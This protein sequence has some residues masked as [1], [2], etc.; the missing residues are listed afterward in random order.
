M[1][2]QITASAFWTLFHTQKNSYS[3]EHTPVPFVEHQ[4]HSCILGITALDAAVAT[5]WQEVILNEWPEIVSWVNTV[6]D[7]N[8]ELQALTESAQG[9]L[10]KSQLVAT[11]RFLVNTGVPE[12]FSPNLVDLAVLI[13]MRKKT[14]FFPTLAKDLVELN[15]FRNHALHTGRKWSEPMA[16]ACIK[17]IMECSR[18]LEKLHP[19]FVEAFETEKT[20]PS[21]GAQPS[22]LSKKIAA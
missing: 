17:Q 15:G 1:K 5:Y 9:I 21:E 12:K 4:R 20:R 6:L 11:L 8:E 19:C 14:A 10:S 7:D 3:S 18:M 2:T 22:L 16:H 13:L